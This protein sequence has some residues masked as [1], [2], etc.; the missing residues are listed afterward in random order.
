MTFATTDV[1][2]ANPLTAVY[3]PLGT[4]IAGSDGGVIYKADAAGNTYSTYYPDALCKQAATA[5]YQPPNIV[6]QPN[7]AGGLVSTDGTSKTIPAF[8]GPSQTVT[9][10]Y[11]S[12]CA[13][14]GVQYAFTTSVTDCTQAACVTSAKGTYSYQYT[15]AGTKPAAAGGQGGQMVAAGP[16]MAPLAVGKSP[17]PTLAPTAEV[18]VVYVVILILYGITPADF[19]KQDADGKLTLA[20]QQQIASVTGKNIVPDNLFR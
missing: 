15:C 17:Y 10:Y 13:A 2:C 20:L 14:T 19:A 8:T 12:G 6:C 7:P 16:T 9:Y 5:Y 4:C 18:V 1:K 3:Y 11:G